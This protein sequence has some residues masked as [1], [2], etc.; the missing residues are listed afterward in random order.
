[1]NHKEIFRCEC[2][3][4]FQESSTQSL[5]RLAWS[6]IQRPEFAHGPTKHTSWVVHPK[7]TVTFPIVII[8][9]T[10]LNFHLQNFS[11]SPAQR[12]MNLSL[13][14]IRAMPTRK[15]AN[16]S[17]SASMET[18]HDETD[19]NLA[20]CSTQKPKHVIGLE[21]LLDGKF[22]LTWQVE[23]CLFSFDFWREK[24]QKIQRFKCWEFV[25]CMLISWKCKNLKKI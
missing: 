12:S 22:L 8:V 1:M 23:V 18:F 20:K 17:M 14:H 4:L 9:S 13:C 21:T 2:F 10:K 6:S 7:V 16:I 24:W 19:A 5:V 15:I 3:L 11:V 25:V